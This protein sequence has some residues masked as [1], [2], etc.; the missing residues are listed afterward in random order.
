ML[1]Q[2]REE[3]IAELKAQVEA[4]KARSDG[5]GTG[6]AVSGTGE[7]G[8]PVKAEVSRPGEA[9]MHLG[10]ERQATGVVEGKAG[11]RCQPWKI[12]WS[13]SRPR[14]VRR[15]IRGFDIGDYWLYVNTARWPRWMKARNPPDKVS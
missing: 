1:E 11:S 4:D 15:T 7:D 9:R 14:R 3:R 2:K 12:F 13:T 6:R 5:S 10:R 8:Q